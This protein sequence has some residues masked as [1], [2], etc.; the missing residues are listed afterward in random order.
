MS[1]SES[2]PK[3][4]AST[5]PERSWPLL[6]KKLLIWAIFL[7]AVY[8]VSNFFLLIFLTFMLCYL[9]LG[10][11]GVCMPWLER[12]RERPWLRRGL[13]VVVLLLIPLVFLGGL[14]LLASRLIGQAQNVSGWL[15]HADPEAE[16]ARVV[17]GIVGPSE[18]AREYGG[19]DDPRFQQGLAEF[20]E[21]GDRYVAE[22]LDFPALEARLEGGFHKR[23]DE[24]ERARQ[25]FRLT[26]EGSS[27][28]AFA[29]WF[30]TQ[31][32]P[33]VKEQARKELAEQGRTGA[34]ADPLLRGAVTDSP[35]QLL[36]AVR[37][38]APTLARLREEWTQETVEAALKAAKASPE[39]EAQFRSYYEERRAAQPSVVPYPFE[40]YTALK[41]ARPQGKQAFAAVLDQH[42]E[43]GTDREARV[44]ADFVAAKR[45][46]LFQK[47]WGDNPVARFCREQAAGRLSDS[48]DKA[49]AWVD[50]ALSTFLDLPLTVATA[51]LLSLFICVD[52]PA[53][54]RGVRRLRNTWL[55]DVYDEVAPALTRLA[56]LIGRSFQAQAVVSACNALLM[57]I[58]LELLGV[59][60]ALVLSI[61][62]FVLCLIPVVGVFL[63]SVPVVLFAL[64]QADGGVVLAVEAVGLI[65]VVHIIETFVLN[66]RIVGK[67]MELHPVLVI[68]LLPV[69]QYFFGI[70]GVI[71]STPVAVYVLY[72]WIFCEEIPGLP[73]RSADDSPTSSR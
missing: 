27:S 45:H 50:A 38:D 71:L 61:L 6:V 7:T 16:I 44:R 8:L 51:L 2:A 10:V 13:T 70:W 43:A 63:S 40:L 64:L 73:S 4:D 47:W 31:K 22:Y 68:G 62:T 42:E 5:H 52:F 69:A 53:L 19:P 60:H 39:G 18:F 34:I 57:L 20:R 33:Q 29:D 3:P 66:P 58:G 35:E 17:E 65:L 30:I 14:G 48:G 36:S 46:E 67:F 24:E 72:E 23:F 37:Q 25:R 11:V 12:G 21:R 1:V 32:Y 26:R 28:Q 49:S 59:D 55:R 54:R 56:H 41:K 15:A 9:T